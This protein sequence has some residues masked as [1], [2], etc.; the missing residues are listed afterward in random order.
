MADEIHLALPT[1]DKE[2]YK[3]LVKESVMEFI[4]DLLIKLQQD[5]PE[6]QLDSMRFYLKLFSL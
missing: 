6:D 3:Y 4:I 1:L 2:F 5:M